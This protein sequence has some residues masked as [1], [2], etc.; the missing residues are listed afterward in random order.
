MRDS[1][2][3]EKEQVGEMTL[4]L[5]FVNKPLPYYIL[6]LTKLYFLQSL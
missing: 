5:W 3:E 4:Q 6:I 2:S 1:E